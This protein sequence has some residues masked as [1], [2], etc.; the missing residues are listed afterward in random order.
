MSQKKTISRHGSSR[1]ATF[2]N[3]ARKLKE[4][5]GGRAGDIGNTTKR[6][7]G[8]LLRMA[9]AALDRL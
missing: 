7:T 9:E 8:K 5:G 1:A 4:V 6:E 3:H 2:G